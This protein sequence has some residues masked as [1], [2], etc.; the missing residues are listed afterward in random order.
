MTLPNFLV[1][2][3]QKAGTSWLDRQLRYH[4]GIYLPTKRKEI[5][6]FDQYYHRGVDWYQDFF[7]SPK[8][9]SAKYQAI[10]EI[11][12]KYIFDPDVP[13][14]IH[15]HIPDC[16]LISILRNPVERA[17]SH[18]GDRV[19]NN[20]E[21]RDFNSVL[22]KYPNIFARGLYSEQLERYLRYFP[23]ENML[24]LI[25]ERLISNPKHAL[26]QIAEFLCVDASMFNNDLA[27]Q[28]VNPFSQPRFPRARAMARNAQ[29]FCRDNNL[30]WIVNTSK[31]IG[32]RR[33][34]GNLGPLPL[35]DTDTRTSLIAKY[36]SDIASLEELLGED[37][38]TW[39]KPT[40]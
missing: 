36:E 35:L 25:F 29:A 3:T 10:G 34:F 12:P 14:R 9:L 39:R 7:P 21:K 18:Y 16:K 37:L 28:R 19:R 17:Y 13:G 5:H 4:P 26:H 11:T 1:I 2:G 27:S 6:F 31:V 23:R 30:D 15:E 20:A 33:L 40:S 22:N 32:I 8:H 24:V 38:S